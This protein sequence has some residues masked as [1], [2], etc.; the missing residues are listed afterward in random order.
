M[1]LVSVCRFCVEWY[2]DHRDLHVLTHSF[3]TRRSS[4][5]VVDA[6]ASA[7]E[8]YQTALA[9]IESLNAEV[10]SSEIALEGVQQEATVGART[11]LDVSDAEQALLDGHVSLVQAQSDATAASHQLLQGVGRSTTP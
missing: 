10:K 2:G 6:A 8:A 7:F 4:D 3:P 5:L 9:R 1:V 11:D